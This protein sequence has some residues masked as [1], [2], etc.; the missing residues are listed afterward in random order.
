MK[1]VDDFGNQGSPPSHPV[2]LD[3]LAVDFVESGWNVK[4]MLKQ[5]TLSAT[6]RQASR[7]TPKLATSDPENIL[8]ARSPRFRLQGEFIRDTALDLSG[9]LVE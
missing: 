2:L 4:R 9:L 8:L 3:W 1:S 6:Y 5:I 7:L